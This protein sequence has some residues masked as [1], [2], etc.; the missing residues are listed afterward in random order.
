V[1]HKVVLKFDCHD[2]SR[3]LY[4]IFA[5]HMPRTKN[6][7]LSTKLSEMAKKRHSQKSRGYGKPSPPCEGRG[8]RSQKKI[9]DTTPRLTTPDG[10]KPEVPMT[11]I[12]LSGYSNIIGARG[13]Q[14][15]ICH[16]SDDKKLHILND[17]HGG[18][19]EVARFAAETYSEKL[20]GVLDLLDKNGQLTMVTASHLFR[21]V[22]LEVDELVKDK[23]SD[24]WRKPGTTVILAYV[25]EGG[26]F[27]YSLGDCRAA[28]YNSQGDVVECNTEKCDL[29][30]DEQIA[31]NLGMRRANTS[32]H[33]FNGRINKPGFGRV[34]VTEESM[35][36]C[37]A[38]KD[39]EDG[40]CLK[41]FMQMNFTA[42]KQKNDSL[43]LLRTKLAELVDSSPVVRTKLRS[44]LNRIEREFG[45]GPEDIIHGDMMSA[46][47][48]TNMT[49]DP[50]HVWRLPNGLQPTRA[51]EA[52]PCTGATILGELTYWDLPKSKRE[53]CTIALWCDGVEDLGASN[54]EQFGRLL[55]EDG[56]TNPES[57]CAGNRIIRNLDISSSATLRPKGAFSIP[58]DIDLDKR[59]TW[60]NSLSK[61][62]LFGNKMERICRLKLP[63]N[64]WKDAVTL[65]TNTVGEF[66]KTEER[67]RMA[68]HDRTDEGLKDLAEMI[69]HYCV[70]RGSSDN[71]SIILV[72][73]ST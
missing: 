37:V 40:T 46:V 68:F 23:W 14:E 70:S 43:A 72:S 38:D 52:D 31:Y 71:C 48:P 30:M 34:V 63:D 16:V 47:F 18:S 39:D 44:E 73:F 49:C 61:E 57:W 54:V 20:K 22:G 3:N 19:D 9:F 15:D 55:T 56:Y 26:V 32:I 27:V 35:A 66:C 45:L 8:K 69:G 5:Q 21:T 7:N 59:M 60:L 11:E 64:T 1:G 58:T 2:W 62:P 33:C 42:L 53:D 29:A 67:K 50:P 36:T 25:A 4:W 6:D 12:L 24:N 41:E 51:L 17:G 10:V 28:V 65:S 13:S